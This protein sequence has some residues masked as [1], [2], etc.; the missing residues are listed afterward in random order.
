MH[1][2]GTDVGYGSGIQCHQLYNISIDIQV[3][4]VRGG[5][6]PRRDEGGFREKRMGE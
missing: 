5:N 1:D 4:H 6:V 2:A 3:I